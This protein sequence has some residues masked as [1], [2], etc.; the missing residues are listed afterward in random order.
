[1]SCFRS[2]SSQTD[3][4][5]LLIRPEFSEI[6]PDYYQIPQADKEEIKKSNGEN[7]EELV[8]SVASK[9]GTT[10]AAL[11]KLDEKGFK[12]IFS[13]AVDAGIKRA[14]ELSMN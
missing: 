9:G 6:N 2:C 3:I 7:L 5:T 14:K 8:E 11:Q 1:M 4:S 10:E 12:K 13:E